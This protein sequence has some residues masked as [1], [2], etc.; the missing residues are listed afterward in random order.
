MN[1]FSIGLRIGKHFV[2]CG[3]LKLKSQSWKTRLASTSPF[4]RVPR[5][6]MNQKTR[7]RRPLSPSGKSEKHGRRGISSI[8]EEFEFAPSEDPPEVSLK[9]LK[10]K[11]GR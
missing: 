5:S 11:P 4:S 1:R 2:R 7:A 10:Q 6:N 8:S 3:M 9:G